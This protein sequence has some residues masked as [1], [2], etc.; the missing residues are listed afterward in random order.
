MASTTK[1]ETDS[2]DLNGEEED[3]FEPLVSSTMP[4]T[5]LTAK[6]MRSLTTRMQQLGDSGQERLS[7][8]PIVGERSGWLIEPSDVELGEVLGKGS[9]ATVYKSRWHGLDVAVKVLDPSCF[10]DLGSLTSFCREL[11]LFSTQRHPHIL[12]F[13]AGTLDIPHKCYVVTSLMDS[14]MTMWLHGCS[15][16]KS[17]RQIPLP[18]MKDRLRVGL[19][20]ALALQHL[21]EQKPMI[22]HR[23]L[24]PSNVFIGGNGHA[25]LS[26]FGFARLLRP[27]DISMTRATGTFMYMAPEVIRSDK[28][29]QRCDVYSFGVLLNE[30]LC[31]YPPFI[32]VRQ[33][34]FQIAEAV[35]KAGIR[36]FLVKTDAD[37]RVI[38]LIKMC[39]TQDP[40]GRPPMSHVTTTLREI[41]ADVHKGKKSRSGKVS[42]GAGNESRSSVM[43]RLF[44]TKSGT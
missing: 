39:W 14:T 43:S 33:A 17:T 37:P 32:E 3:Q 30:V 2:L 34:P 36:P 9:T 7:L 21:H 41:L 23:D 35:V 4:G 13:L 20:V 29:D 24:K 27:G 11:E 5:Q 15:E 1:D 8:L 25:F 42:D 26:D 44:K 6:L 38:D 22:I 18:P 16:R 12:P 28:Y 19:E 31:G 40:D 10:D